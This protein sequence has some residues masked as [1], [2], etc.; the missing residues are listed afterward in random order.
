MYFTH[1]VISHRLT[2][3]SR[4]AAISGASLSTWPASQLR[5]PSLI[6]MRW[7]ALLAQLATICKRLYRQARQRSRRGRS[8]ADN[9]G[10]GGCVFHDREGF[11]MAGNFVI[12]DGSLECVNSVIRVVNEVA[13]SGSFVIVDS[14]GQI[15]PETVHD[16][17][18]GLEGLLSGVMAD[19]GGMAGTSEV[20]STSGRRRGVL[21]RRKADGRRVDA[22][23]GRRGG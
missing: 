17:R 4:N 23:R 16:H 18:R 5:P 15:A 9:A 14:S 12:M 21:G 8:R 19:C 3:S 20:V 22:G 7:T 2:P 1:I 11:Y 10:C 6:A 13:S